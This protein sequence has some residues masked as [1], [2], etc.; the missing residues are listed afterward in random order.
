ME[1]VPP[2]LMTVSLVDAHPL[3]VL[4]KTIKSVISIPKKGVDDAREEH[5]NGALFFWKFLSL[6]KT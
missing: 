2:A 4:S 6:E 1:S 3:C 5:K